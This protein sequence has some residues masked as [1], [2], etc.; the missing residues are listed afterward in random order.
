MSRLEHRINSIST[1]SELELLVNDVCGFID[2]LLRISKNKGKN[3]RVQHLRMGSYGFSQHI[4]YYA[5]ARLYWGEN[6]R[7]IP[8]LLDSI[9]IIVTRRLILEGKNISKMFY[10]TAPKHLA[11]IRDSETEE[12]QMACLEK[13]RKDLQDANEN[14]SDF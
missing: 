14:P 8:E 4:L 9:E 5:A 7:I 1:L 11:M 12:E 3:G 10:A 2:Q 6:S 13:I